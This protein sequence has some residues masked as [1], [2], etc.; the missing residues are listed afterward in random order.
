MS[1]ISKKIDEVIGTRV[2]PL[3]KNAG[4]KKKARNF[5]REHEDRVELINIQ[6]SQFNDGAE[7]KLTVNIGVYFPAITEI[8]EAPP[9]KGMPKEYNCTIRKRIGSLSTEKQD[10][11]WS[12]GPDTDLN[13]VAVD[14]AQKV[15]SVCFPWL[16]EMASLEKAKLE[17][18]K[19]IPFIAA[20]I[21][22]HL[23]QESEAKAYLEQCIKQKP[24][25]KPRTI[26]WGKKH[27]L[28]KT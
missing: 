17:V 18:A 3:L 20:G 19:K 26:A 12:V 4:F 7:G 5:H 13:E 8:T 6:A 24:T 21:S 9:V 16:E 25:A 22:L 27:G 14:L 23:G 11:W 10:T 2:A 15:E 28:I 1:E